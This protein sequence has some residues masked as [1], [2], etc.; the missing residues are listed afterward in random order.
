MQ[1]RVLQI[2]DSHQIIHNAQDIIVLLCLKTR[3]MRD[4]LND[5]K[6]EF[7]APHV[8]QCTWFSRI[9]LTLAAHPP[10]DIP[11][12]RTQQLV[13]WRITSPMGTKM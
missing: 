7:Q 9:R 10:H 11:C 2:H 13:T 8:A 4:T 1:V 12:T 3:A 6:F 5:S